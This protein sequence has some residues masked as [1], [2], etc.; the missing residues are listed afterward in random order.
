MTSIGNLQD[1]ENICARTA[2]SER[3]WPNSE[4]ESLATKL[5]MIV[6]EESQSDNNTII[7][8]QFRNKYK[9]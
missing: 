4:A 5:V 6:H 7:H 8:K 2:E 3:V 1:E 9:K